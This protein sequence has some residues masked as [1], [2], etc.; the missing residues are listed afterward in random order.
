MA[1]SGLFGW[2]KKMKYWS[3]DN[4]SAASSPKQLMSKLNPGPAICTPMYRSV[5]AVRSLIL[6]LWPR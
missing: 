1:S 6:A 5:P 2:L 3:S 4:W